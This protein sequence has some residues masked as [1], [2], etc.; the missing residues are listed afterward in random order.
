MRRSD[1]YS[2][3]ENK[4]LL[5]NSVLFWLSRWHQHKILFVSMYLGRR[6]LSTDSSLVLFLH[7]RLELLD[8][9]SSCKQ[10]HV[11]KFLQAAEI[12]NRTN[13]F[14]PFSLFHLRKNTLFFGNV[15][16]ALPIYNAA[17]EAKNITTMMMT[18]IAGTNY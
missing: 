17:M 10:H 15:W 5:N 13:T 7:W 8:R 4:T 16:V 6:R 1:I 14:F 18:I 9:L 3:S 12:G 11:M 2:N